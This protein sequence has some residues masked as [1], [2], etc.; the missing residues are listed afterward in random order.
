MGGRQKKRGLLECAFEVLSRR[1]ISIT[2][3]AMPRVGGESSIL[4]VSSA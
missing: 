3:C 2:S 1:T 4:S